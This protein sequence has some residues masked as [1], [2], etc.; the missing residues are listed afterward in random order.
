MEYIKN[1]YNIDNFGFY[2]RKAIFQGALPILLALMTFFDFAKQSGTQNGGSAFNHLYFYTSFIL[3]IYSQIKVIL[4]FIFTSCTENVI[5]K[6]EINLDKSISLIMLSVNNP[7]TSQDHFIVTIKK[8]FKLR[9]S[10][11]VYFQHI[12][13]FCYLIGMECPLLIPYDIVAKLSNAKDTITKENEQQLLQMTLTN[14]YSYHPDK[15]NIIPLEN[16]IY[17]TNENTSLIPKTIV[18]PLDKTIGD[19]QKEIFNIQ[20]HQGYMPNVV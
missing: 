14:L 7:A 4:E 15:Y 5:F 10:N 1:I 3:L 16:S 8:I 19:F 6:K 9:Y 12:C 17:P 2:L 11:S 18:T 20:G 13:N